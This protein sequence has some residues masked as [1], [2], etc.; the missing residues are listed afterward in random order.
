MK[1]IGSMMGFLDFVAYTEEIK[2]RQNFSNRYR[3]K[4][5]VKCNWLDTPVVHV[6]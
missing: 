4:K 5:W 1:V 6:A 3:L 2:L